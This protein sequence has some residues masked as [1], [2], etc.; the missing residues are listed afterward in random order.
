MR[1]ISSISSILHIHRSIPTFHTYCQLRGHNHHGH[2]PIH[3]NGK[4]RKSRQDPEGI[5]R[6]GCLV[7]GASSQPYQDLALLLHRPR[8]RECARPVGRAG[9]SPVQRTSERRNV[10]TSERQNVR[11]QNSKRSRS[12][13]GKLRMNCEGCN[14]G[15]QVDAPKG[16]MHSAHSGEPR[17]PPQ[18]KKEQKRLPVPQG[19]PRTVASGL[20]HGHAMHKHPRG[21]PMR[22][23]RLVGSEGTPSSNAGSSLKA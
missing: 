18:T 7:Q 12:D 1:I 17:R 16:A 23:A 10:R 3:H 21:R 2:P 13:S 20:V 4:H 9:A 11:T 6:L 5:R 15:Q 14:L 8:S 19:Q 22:A